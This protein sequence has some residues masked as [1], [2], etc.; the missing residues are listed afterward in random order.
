MPTEA[1]TC[2]KFVV[3]KLQAAGLGQRAYSI[4]EQRTIGRENQTL[5]AMKRLKPET[6]AQFDALLPS[7]LDKLSKAN[8]KR[9]T[10]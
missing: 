8:C 10:N 5:E 2:R 3:R 4:A 1:D 7:I 9:T 6:A